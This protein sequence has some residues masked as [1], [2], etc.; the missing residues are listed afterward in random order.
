MILNKQDLLMLWRFSRFESVREVVQ[1]RFGLKARG[2]ELSERDILDSRAS[3][4][5]FVLL[6]RARNK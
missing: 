4:D 1:T 6:Q 2:I 3:A 5:I